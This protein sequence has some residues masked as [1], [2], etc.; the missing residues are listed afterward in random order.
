MIITY[1][2]N[3]SPTMLET[4]KK[5]EEHGKLVRYTGGFWSWERCEQ[6][7]CCGDMVPDWHCDIKTL[8]ALECRGLVLLDEWD[9]RE[10][11]LIQRN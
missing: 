1:E 5:I 6:H 10:V 4:I 7:D 8:R 11:T 2:M 9:K 3:L